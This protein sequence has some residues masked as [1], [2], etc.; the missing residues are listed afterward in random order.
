MI[1]RGKGE[2]RFWAFFFTS[3]ARG[4]G[5]CIC[6]RCLFTTQ[7]IYPWQF[8]FPFTD[9]RILDWAGWKGSSNSLRA[10]FWLRTNYGS[11]AL[12][13]TV[14]SRSPWGGSGNLLLMRRVRG[15]GQTLASP[16]TMSGEFIFSRTLKLSGCQPSAGLKPALRVCLAQLFKHITDGRFL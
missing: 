5:H 3:L 6:S 2:T 15:R 14:G 8:L 1:E 13:I 12:F 10:R 9:K 7:P 4:A 11:M 16:Q